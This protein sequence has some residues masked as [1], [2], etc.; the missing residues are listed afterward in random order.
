MS[1]LS[2][3]VAIA[4]LGILFIGLLCL[5]ENLPGNA[6]VGLRIPEARKSQ[7]YWNMGHKIAGPAWTGSG[8]AMLAA[9][10]VAWS[11]AGWT[12]LVVAGL[13]VASLFLL[14]MG[15][16]LAAHAMAQVDARAQ[17]EADAESGCCSSGPSASSA[18]A[19]DTCCGGSAD[20]SPEGQAAADGVVSAD[21]CASGQACGSCSLNGSCKGGGAAYDSAPA[22]DLDAARRAVASQDTQ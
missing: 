3:I 19:S 7:D 11:A 16:A 22:L 6:L 4:G 1:F 18:G 14:G 5:T 12:W 9:G 13:V 15:G 21:A 2:I 20:V 8:L 10:A 17:K